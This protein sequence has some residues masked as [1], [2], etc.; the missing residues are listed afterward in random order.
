MSFLIIDSDQKFADILAGQLTKEFEGEVHIKEDASEAIGLLELLD[1]F[2][3]VFGV[4]SSKTKN[5][6]DKLIKFLNQNTLSHKPELILLGTS[7]S[8]KSIDPVL[9]LPITTKVS[10]VIGL[11][12]TK[13]KFKN[14]TDKIKENSNQEYANIPL[15]LFHYINTAPG[16]LYLKLKKDGKPHMVKRINK[17]DA[18][19]EA[20]LSSLKDKGVKFLYVEK[21]EVRYFFEVFDKRM[22]EL[23][24][25]APDLFLSENDLEN[26][27][28]H[29][30]SKFGVSESSLRIAQV[31]SKE[32][33]KKLS[34][35]N[36][37]Q[38]ALKEIVKGKGLG[39]KQLNSK[40]IALISH[41]IIKN[42]DLDT[43]QARQNLVTASLLQDCKLSN[44]Y[45]A[46]R[47]DSELQSFYLDDKEN[48]LIDRHAALAAD[49]LDKFDAISS[50][51][52]KIVRHHHGT[53]DGKGFGTELKKISHPLSLVFILAEEVSFAIIK[54]ERSS[55][56]LNDILDGISLKYGNDSKL[57]K[58]IDQFKDNL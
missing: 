11:L 28:F 18:L 54:R 25:K 8:E 15:R 27:A 53:I 32:A 30:L 21:E 1:D 43:S 42:S 56:N 49:H 45:A 12:K 2:N 40:M 19:E 26:Y 57:D 38:K 52:V 24:E 41:F 50:E 51:V 22:A 44:D 37:F 7:P 39:T 23:A 34:E 13:K 31:A 47:S 14:N 6:A 10:E 9:I 16:D 17:N 35:D 3:F 58:L 48:V 29:S 33:V 4:K 46:I 36:N 20:Y 5:M 55:I